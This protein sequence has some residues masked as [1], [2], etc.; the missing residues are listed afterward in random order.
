M[1]TRSPRTRR[2]ATGSP[3]PRPVPSAEGALSVTRA[4][5]AEA[6]AVGRPLRGREHHVSNDF[7]YV[8]RDLAAVAVIGAV[9]LAFIVAMSFVV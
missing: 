5:A 9:S 7:S 1:A 6:V 8:K 3:L 2:R 4:P